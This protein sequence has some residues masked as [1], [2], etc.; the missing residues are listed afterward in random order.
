MAF[1]AMQVVQSSV[2]ASV[3][4]VLERTLGTFS[5]AA[6]GAL[7]ATFAAH[8]HLPFPAVA[9]LG[10]APA[11]FLAALYP[12]FRIAPIT[13][14]IVLFG[15]NHLNLPPLEYA[16]HR[17]LEIGIGCV[18][19]LAVALSVFP[20]RA[21][22][23]IAKSAAEVLENYAQL[24]LQLIEVASGKREYASAEIKHSELRAAITKME[25]QGEDAKRERLSRLTDEPDPDPLLRMIRRIRFDLVMIG[26]A[27][28]QPL[29]A[30]VAVALLAP[31]NEVAQQSSSLLRAG[32]VALAAEKRRKP[33]RCS[34]TPSAHSPPRCRNC[35]AI[36][37][38][39]R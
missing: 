15:E 32:A 34:I 24:L 13:I 5:G 3:K 7:V 38:L 12:S 2:G 19:G 16:E 8:M 18:I 25:T 37:L 23:A 27:V 33:R 21:H 17:V 31:L 11:A 9:V 10:I 29:P 35:I 22:R 14:A 36:M 39:P 20:S 30:P 6:Y 1:S 28:N 4:A 26:R